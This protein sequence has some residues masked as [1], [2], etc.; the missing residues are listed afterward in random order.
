M[1]ATI[2]LAEDDENDAFFF[3][4]ALKRA[5]LA[6]PVQRVCDGREALEYLQGTGAFGDRYKFPLPRLV[7]LDLKLP[8]IM[9]LEVL[10]WIRDQDQF[11]STTVIVLSAS[12]FPDDLADARRHG[13][14]G[15]FVKPSDLD[16][17]DVIART[18]CDGWINA[19]PS[20]LPMPDSAG[21]AGSLPR[22]P[23]GQVPVRLGVAASA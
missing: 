14:D 4:R 11:N 2:L 3:E 23:D 7:L 5:G 15:Y 6:N 16:Q 9:G 22:F 20:S 21:A 12:Q 19:R 8:Q 10:K 17:L 13:A 18:V 1:N